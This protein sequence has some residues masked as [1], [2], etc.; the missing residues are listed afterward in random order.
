[1]RMDD[2]K[3]ITEYIEQQNYDAIVELGRENNARTLRYVQMNIWGDYRQLQRWHAITAL[4]RLAE[5]FA[6]QQDEA[7]R[8]VIRRAIWAMADESG[9]VPWAAPEMMTVVIK[10]RPQQYR[11]F[12][13]IMITNGLDSPMCRL[14]VLWSIGYLGPDYR[15]DV[16][17]YMKK[18]MKLLNNK[19]K[20]VR[21]M[22]AW[23]LKRIQ[24]EPAYEKI[25]SLAGDDTIL[26]IYEDGELK[27]V[28]VSQAI[29]EG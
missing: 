15:A 13:K 18:I 17:P 27:Q 26:W 22:T 23:A 20:E 25:E 3:K 6:A 2:K 14:G 28:P 1:M 16:E 5:A 9:N 10:A 24:Y 29:R 8:N 21:G 19:D 4:G 12:V 7:Y 11:E